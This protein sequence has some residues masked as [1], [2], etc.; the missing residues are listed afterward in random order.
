MTLP[1]SEISVDCYF[2]TCRTCIIIVIIFWQQGVGIED[3]LVDE[4]GYPRADVNLYQIRTARHS[5]S[6][7]WRHVRAAVRFDLM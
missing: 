3:S 5:I 1:Y 6:C 7:K 2:K 4:E